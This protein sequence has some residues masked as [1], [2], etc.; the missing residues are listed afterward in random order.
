MSIPVDTTRLATVLDDFG[1]G[2]LLS[3][4]ADGRVKVVTVEPSVDGDR[5]VVEHP[6]K[7]STG[8]IAQNPI[9]TVLFPPGE[10]RGYSL[11]VDGT[12]EVVD[13]VA[14]ITP[15]AA[16]LHR[17]AAHADGPTIPGSC[18]HDCQPIS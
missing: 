18:A 6:G 15:T 14:S 17:P 10:L 5:L 9:V 1:V 16:V 4:S 2:Y 7:G 8:N 13:E 3:T 11:I 12:A